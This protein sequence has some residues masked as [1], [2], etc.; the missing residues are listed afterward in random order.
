MG[1][2]TFNNPKTGQSFTVSGPETLT[3]AQ[4]KEIFDKQLNT[5]ALVG[6]K[7]G[8]IINSAKQALGGVVGA[9]GS[10]ISSVTGAISGALGKLPGIAKSLTG[11]APTNPVNI[12]D[13][14]KSA[15]GLMPIA[16]VNPSQITAGMAGLTKLVDQPPS[17]LSNVKG[18]GSFGLDANQLQTAGFLKPGTTNLLADGTNSLSSVLKSPSVWTGKEG[19]SSLQSLL[20]NASAQSKIQQNLMATGAAGLST[21][22]INVSSLSPAA[23]TGTL[24]N[25]AKSVT[26][27]AAWAQGVKLPSVPGS[28]PSLP[29]LPGTPDVAGMTAGMDAT[30]IAGSFG[31]KL[32]NLKANP[33]VLQEVKPEG[34]ADTVDRA[35]VNAAADR[36][37]GDPKVPKLDYGGGEVTGEQLKELFAE[38]IKIIDES[39]ALLDKTKELYTPIIDRTFTMSITSAEWAALDAAY[40][41]AKEK[42]NGEGKA[43]RSKLSSAWNRA[44]DSVKQPYESLLININNQ[45]KLLA[46]RAATIR[47][48]I[49]QLKEKISG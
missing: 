28:L 12:G 6:L 31:V 1:K 26:S 9:I 11:S 3:E 32:S 33:P 16:G 19:I 14:A 8:D 2:Y 17:V 13:I 18:V 48:I 47:S 35:T 25:A 15:Q 46:S 37:V 30:A 34:A 38:Y 10:A 22:G 7:P 39:E 44:T 43:V 24:L 21:L 40:V 45:A 36:I 49:N 42:F 27:T 29:P 23:A 41:E 5:G 20:T 4:A